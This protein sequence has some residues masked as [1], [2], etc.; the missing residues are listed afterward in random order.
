VQGAERAEPLEPGGPPQHAEPVKADGSG[1]APD[2]PG[3]AQADAAALPRTLRLPPH[4]A[5]LHRGPSSRLLGL[6]PGT[7]LVVDDLSPPLAQMLDELVAPVDRDG[8]IARAVRR[9]ADAVA[10]DDLLCRLVV[11]GARG[12][13][14]ARERAA[15]R[16]AEAVVMVS[17]TGPL[18]VG[19]AAG[20]AL[21]G[22]GTVHTAPTTAPATASVRASTASS[23]RAASTATG[24]PVCARDLGT[25][26]VDADR[27]RPR[28]DA[29]LDVVRRVVP[30]ARAGPAPRRPL[31][32]LCVLADAAAPDPV[33][34]AELHRT[35]LAHLPVRLRD[36]TGVVGPLVLPGRSACLGCFELHRR[37]RDPDWPAV[38][39]QLLGREGSAEPEA[40]AATAALGVAQVLAVL[41]GGTCRAAPGER[42][43]STTGGVPPVLDA[44][45]ELDLVA[46][47]LLR[48][49]WMS[50]PDCTCGAPRAETSGPPDGRGTITG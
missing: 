38:A 48:R 31:P 5:L 43:R 1:R 25:G 12:D 24:S 10:A 33:Q 27:G 44:T 9:G 46:G 42:D 3:S 37:A 22:V 45:L 30:G 4:R 50:H 15:R 23:T 18:A 47:T 36:G 19:V 28:A 11:A 21:A 40:A 49:P 6:D 26:L 2:R 14:A 7:A 16:R 20:L 29:L 13:A 41:D 8:L 39:A 32:D 34:I 17:G 35:R